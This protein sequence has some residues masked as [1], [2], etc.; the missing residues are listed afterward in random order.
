MVIQDEKN[1]ILNQDDLDVIGNL[2]N[3]FKF[4]LYSVSDNEIDLPFNTFEDYV[5]SDIII[6][7]LL[8][9]KLNKG[10]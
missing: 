3:D 9:S 5:A 2:L 6:S 1:E 8:K 10:E 7:K 4:L